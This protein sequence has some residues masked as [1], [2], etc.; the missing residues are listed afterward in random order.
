MSKS[1]KRHSRGEVKRQDAERHV[2][3]DQVSMAVRI[4]MLTWEIV[5]TLVREHVLRGTGPAGKDAPSALNAYQGYSQ[6]KYETHS[7]AGLAVR[8]DPR[9]SWPPA[10]LPVL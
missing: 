5:W 10:G 9:P 8:R 3:T 2:R 4:A 7:G 1:G 6:D